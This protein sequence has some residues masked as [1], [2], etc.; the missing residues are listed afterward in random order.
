MFQGFSFDDLV[1]NVQSTARRKEDIIVKSADMRYDAVTNALSAGDHI[2]TL[3]THA[4]NQLAT[5]TGIDRNYYQRML[6]TSQA[7]GDGVSRDEQLA[8]QSLLEHNVNNW[9]H[10]RLKTDNGVEL[11]ERTRMLRTLTS[12]A[13]P[14]GVQGRALLSNAYLRLDHEHVLLSLM[15][16]IQ[17]L[18]LTV[19]SCNVS[20]DRLYV[21][22]VSPR[23][24]GEVRKGDVVRAGVS[25]SNGEIGNARAE[26][27]PFIERLVCTN[28]LILPD[29][30]FTNASKMKM[31]HVGKRLQGDASAYIASKDTQYKEIE[32]RMAHA[33]DAIDFALHP[34]TLNQS[35]TLL[36]GAA[37]GP[38]II[39]PLGAAVALSSLL[40]LTK[41]E[42]DAM[43]VHL[44]QSGDM[45]RYGALNAV[46]RLAHD[47]TAVRSYDRASELEALGARVLSLS[48]REWSRIAEADF[49][50]GSRRRKAA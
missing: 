49:P 24:Q 37:E 39:R 11:R 40:G 23:R 13:T 21:K 7:A 45:S 34:D 15:P 50:D 3:T 25:I 17:E 26:V 42:S 20:D 5:F 48:P 35:L 14:T 8:A 22:A 33:R 19:V 29:S 38:Q 28:G 43:A 36:R 41:P 2:A 30:A 6:L 47:D 10:S 9:L 46:T 1:R 27:S 44:I 18:G 4:H 31:R 12:A 32:A 16:Y